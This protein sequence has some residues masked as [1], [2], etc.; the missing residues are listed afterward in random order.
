MTKITAKDVAE[1]EK[2]FPPTQDGKDEV[3]HFLSHLERAGQATLGRYKR[4]PSHM[5]DTATQGMVEYWGK[6]LSVLSWARSINGR[7][8]VRDDER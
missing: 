7:R 4:I 6:A 5:R 8:K 2:L 3:D 1:G